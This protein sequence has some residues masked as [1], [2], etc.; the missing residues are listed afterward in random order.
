MAESRPRKLASA[1]RLSANSFQSN[2]SLTGKAGADRDISGL[3]W[4]HGSSA[5]QS[6]ADN[7]CPHCCFMRQGPQPCSPAPNRK[8]P[9]LHLYF[10]DSKNFLGV[11]AS[12]RSQ[13]FAFDPSIS[14]F[15]AT[16]LRRGF[17]NILREDSHGKDEGR[18]SDPARR[19][20]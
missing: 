11:M 16:F 9:R 8:C 4:Q 2:R 14:Q 10:V 13:K 17:T 20:D 15:L 6:P 7:P 5:C 3:R 18:A 19:A 1:P 12:F